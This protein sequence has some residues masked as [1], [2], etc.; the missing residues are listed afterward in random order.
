MCGFCSKLVSLSKPV[1]ETDTR[2]DT[3]YYKICLF[4]GN[5]EPVMFY[6]MPKMPKRYQDIITSLKKCDLIHNNDSYKFS[7]TKDGSWSQTFLQNALQFL[8]A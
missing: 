5:Y 2:K 7:H 3:A 8:S 1:K 4:S 6:N